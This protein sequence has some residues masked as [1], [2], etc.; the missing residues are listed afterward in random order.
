MSIMTCRDPATITWDNQPRLT[1]YRAQAS[2]TTYESELDVYVSLVHLR[3]SNLNIIKQQMEPN[4]ITRSYFCNNA[5]RRRP[6]E[7]CKRVF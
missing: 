6:T 3:A 4:E 1:S 7:H 2:S 5:Q